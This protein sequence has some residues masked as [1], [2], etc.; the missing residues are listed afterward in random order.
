M[1][2]MIAFGMGAVISGLTYGQIIDK[3]GSRQACHLN[4]AMIGVQGI[5]TILAIQSTGFSSL[6]ILLCF[7]W[8]LQDGGVNI[9]CLQI[10]GFE[11]ESHSEPFGVFN[12]MNGVGVA[13]FQAI[14]AFI[15][16]EDKNQLI[17]YTTF[18][19]L[20]GMTCTLGTFYMD[21]K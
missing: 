16:L 6:S 10:L 15:N 5:V 12:I 7:L 19:S 21:F 17:F 8:G 20:F 11:F 2:G 9:H 4:M 1:Q 3:I 18:I 14:Q 13:I